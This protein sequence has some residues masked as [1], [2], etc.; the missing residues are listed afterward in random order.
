MDNFSTTYVYGGLGNVLFQISNAYSYALNHSKDFRLYSDCFGHT[1][2]TPNQHYLNNI[3]KNIKIE[4]NQLLSE[5]FLFFK[6][7]DHSYTPIHNIESSVCFDGYYQS[8]KY[9]ID[10]KDNINKLFNVEYTS[11]PPNKC[12]IHVRRGDYLNYQNVYEILDV[13]YYNKAMDI[14]G[15]DCEFYIFTN[16]VLWCNENFK[17]NNIHIIDEPDPVKTFYKLSSFKKIIISNSTFS[18]WAAFLNDDDK[19]V[20]SPN[21]W[22]KPEYLQTLTCKKYD[23]WINDLILPHWIKI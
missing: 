1:S 4:E 23:Q 15:Y 14:I 11:I 20:V 22:F 10:Y 8:Y 2:H 16:D 5:N 3:L 18:W 12:A 17:K 13:E 7:T 19:V 21:K 6:E 9:F